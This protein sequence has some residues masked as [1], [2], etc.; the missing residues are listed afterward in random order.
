MN[1]TTSPPA[2]LSRHAAPT[3][4]D[5]VYRKITLRIVPLLFIGFMLNYMDRSN[6]GFAKLQMEGALGFGD[7]VY[8]LAAGIFF[9]GYAL[10]E[11]PSNLVLKRLGARRT[12]LRIMVLWG[13]V[14]AATMFVTTPTHFYVARFLLGVFEA[15]FFPGIVLYMTFWFPRERRART[16]SWFIM[17]TSAAAI[18]T[19]PLSGWIMKNL[20]GVHGWDGW[21]WMFLLEGLPSVAFG[22]VLY[23]LLSD[24]PAQAAWLSEREKSIVA[25]SLAQDA[26]DHPAT[27]RAGLGRALRNP[28]VYVLSLIGF[29]VVFGVYF[30]S[31]WAPSMLRD[32][33]VADV[34]KVG[35]YILVPNLAAAIFMVL[36]C[37]RSDLR[38]ERRGHFCAAVVLSAIGFLAGAWAMDQGSIPTLVFVFTLA[39]CGAVA[40]IPIFW[41]ESTSRLSA[42]EAPAGIAL[43]STLTNCGGLVSPVAIGAIKTHTGSLSGGLYLAAALLVVAALLMGWVTRRPAER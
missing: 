15:G 37:R 14:S 22:F 19:G 17:A 20:H 40:A 9:V 23:A 34:Q 8:G 33:G 16:V 24:S 21:Q 30:L 32:L 18:V 29:M 2:T 4:L 38:G 13:L 43:I 25:R 28:R 26:D 5:A 12:F 6:V 10:F 39:T 11:V 35:L 41:A 1:S 27:P 42:E 36:Y 3:E 7:A 31:F